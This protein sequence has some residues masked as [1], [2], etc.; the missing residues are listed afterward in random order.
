MA[1]RKS[2]IGQLRQ[3]VKF[4]RNE[5]TQLGAGRKDHYVE[6]ANCRGRLRKI[7]GNRSQDL[8]DALLRSTWTCEIRFHSEVENYIGKSVRLVID[9]MFFTIDRIE[10]IDQKR[11]RYLLHLNEAQ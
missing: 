1:V 7:N 2:D 10:L 6:M 9:N 5:P 8:A 4:E 11:H 3:V